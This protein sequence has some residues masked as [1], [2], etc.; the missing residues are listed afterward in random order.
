MP[1]YTVDIDIPGSYEANW[2]AVEADNPENALAIAKS[3]YLLKEKHSETA[4]QNWD[5]A[6]LTVICVTAGK[7]DF[8]QWS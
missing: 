2:A 7:P 6:D 4:T 5:K 8:K 3:E 1:F